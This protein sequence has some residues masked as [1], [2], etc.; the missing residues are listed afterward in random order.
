[1][2]NHLLRPL[3]SILSGYGWH[4]IWESTK[5]CMCLVGA[6]FWYVLLYRVIKMSPFTWQLQ[7]RKLQAMFKVSPA[8]LQ[9]CF[10]TLNCVLEDTRLTLIPS[11]VPNSNYVIMVSDW[12]SLKYFCVFLYCNHQVHR[13]FLI[14]LYLHVNIVSVLQIF[15]CFLNWKLFHIQHSFFK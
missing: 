1:M 10:E 13:D 2:L 12:N 3:W 15:S 6:S 14:T 5:P 11:V 8:S 4:T 7:Y 9:A